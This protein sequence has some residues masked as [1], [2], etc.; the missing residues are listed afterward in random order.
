MEAVFVQFRNFVYC[1]GLSIAF[2]N[3]NSLIGVAPLRIGGGGGGFCYSPSW[4]QGSG[5]C[6]GEAQ[7]GGAGFGRCVRYDGG[8]GV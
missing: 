2:A 5:A 4:D 7:A 1:L 3:A 6:G 8:L